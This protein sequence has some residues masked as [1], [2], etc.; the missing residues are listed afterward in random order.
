LTYMRENTQRR[1][2]SLTAKH[3]HE[4]LSHE[5]ALTGKNQ[6]LSEFNPG[7]RQTAKKI[8]W[9]APRSSSLYMTPMTAEPIVRPGDEP[10]PWIIARIEAAVL[11]EKQQHRLTESVY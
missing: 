6:Y 9:T 1:K 5:D 3:G 10:T 2:T 7:N 11:I 8:P 4:C